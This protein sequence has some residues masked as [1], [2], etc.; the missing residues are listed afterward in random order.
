MNDP[1]LSVTVSVPIYTKY[2]KAPK[3]F[4]ES[5]LATFGLTTVGVVRP[6][7]EVPAEVD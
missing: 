5:T 4:V 6:S 3:L 1:P 2:T 7:V